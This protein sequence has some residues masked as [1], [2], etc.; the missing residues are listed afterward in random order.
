MLF[1]IALLMIMCISVSVS[2]NSTLQDCTGVW[3]LQEEPISTLTISERP[4]GRLQIE[5]FFYRIWNMEGLATVSGDGKMAVFQSTEGI[6]EL[7]ILDYNGDTISFRVI[8]PP[9]SAGDFI[10]DFLMDHPFVYKRG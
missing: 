1:E 2:A 8:V 9:E 7:G 5:A 3:Q 6:G 4:D 10:Y